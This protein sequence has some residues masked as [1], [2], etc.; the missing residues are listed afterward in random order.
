[1][2]VIQASPR[3]RLHEAQFVPA[4]NT[5]PY[6]AL[7]ADDVVRSYPQKH[8]KHDHPLPDIH[9]TSTSYFSLK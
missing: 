6:Q 7:E 5:P 2:H 9:T 8:Y 4:Y 3:L 1:M